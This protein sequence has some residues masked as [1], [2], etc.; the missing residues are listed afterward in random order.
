MPKQSLTTTSYLILGLVRTL[1]PCTSYDMKQLV[2]MSIGMFWSF[3]HSQLYAEPIRLVEKGLLTEDQ[4][5]TGRKRRQYELTTAG[6][7]ALDAWLRGP[8]DEPTELRDIG[9]LRLFF[10]DPLDDE[11]IRRMATGRRRMHL[12]RL[13]ELERT[14]DMVEDVASPAKLRTMEIGFLWEKTAAEFWESVA[15]DPPR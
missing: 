12:D 14:K 2:S 3:P 13:A 7:H 11:S 6:E 15:S 1:Q 8:N 9:L 5:T 10:A 4:E